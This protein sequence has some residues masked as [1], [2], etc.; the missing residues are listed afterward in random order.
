MKKIVI[1]E[2]EGI[3][4]NSN[5]QLI[6]VIINKGLGTKLVKLAKKNGASGGTILYGNGS[7]SK[8]DS[9]SIFGLK[10]HPEKEIVM[11]AVEKELKDKLLDLIAKKVKFDEPGGGIAFI[12]NLKTFTGASHLLNINREGLVK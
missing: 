2:S 8:E 3:D 11:I 5:Y 10:F 4:M 7:I 12:L 1:Q 6:V 9:E